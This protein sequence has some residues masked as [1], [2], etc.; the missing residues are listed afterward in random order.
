MKK[1][2]SILDFVFSFTNL[3]S[4]E[5]AHLLSQFINQEDLLFPKTDK[6]WG[7]ILLNI[8]QQDDSVDLLKA[9]RYEVNDYLEACKK[10]NPEI[11]NVRQMHIFWDDDVFVEKP[12]SEPEDSWGYTDEDADW[13]P[14]LP[15]EKLA[16]AIEE[17][18]DEN[19]IFYVDIEE[20]FS[21]EDDDLDFPALLFLLAS[22]QSDDEDDE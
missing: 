17:Y 19:N 4:E 18:E 20:Y 13:I 8:I 21:E 9:F 7:Q 10:E 3:N 11:Y 1:I 14:E 16:A 6:I 5:N 12:K 22:C 15:A 2:S